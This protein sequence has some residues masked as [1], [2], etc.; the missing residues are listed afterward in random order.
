MRRCGQITLLDSAK[1]SHFRRTCAQNG[2][3]ASILPT[4]NA[5]LA[6]HQKT[7]DGE[8]PRPAELILRPAQKRYT[9]PNWMARGP[10]PSIELYCGPPIFPNVVLLMFWSLTKKFG[11]LNK[12]KKLACNSINCRSVILVSLESEKL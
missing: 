1:K 12:L 11:W 7:G 5:G 6:P 3:E 2:P 8:R 10:T 4:R 9:S